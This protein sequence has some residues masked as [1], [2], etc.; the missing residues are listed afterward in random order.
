MDTL[1]LKKPC[2]NTGEETYEKKPKEK[3]ADGKKA[4]KS[5]PLR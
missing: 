5:A 3:G 2:K 4:L 1:Y